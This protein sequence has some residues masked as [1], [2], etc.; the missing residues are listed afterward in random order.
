MAK[1]N[2]RR[3]IAAGVGSAAPATWAAGFAHSEEDSEVDVGGLSK[4]P[5][6]KL[7]AACR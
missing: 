6:T 3:S 5:H 2:R 7:A 4:G 1:I